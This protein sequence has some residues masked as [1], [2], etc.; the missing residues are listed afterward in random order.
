MSSIF[1]RLFKMP[2]QYNSFDRNINFNPEIG[3][4]R[5]VQ[6]VGSILK[7]K[8]NNALLGVQYEREQMG[9]LDYLLILPLIPWD[10]LSHVMMAACENSANNIFETAERI[11]DRLEKFAERSIWR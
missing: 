3:F 6:D 5:R 1:G 10:T 2:I 11:I 4:A 7:G 9:V 8:H